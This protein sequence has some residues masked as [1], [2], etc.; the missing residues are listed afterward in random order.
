[1]K[2]SLIDHSQPFQILNPWEV[3]VCKNQAAGAQKYQLYW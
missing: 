2:Q 3:D 1:M